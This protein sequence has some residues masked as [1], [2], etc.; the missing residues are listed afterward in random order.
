LAMLFITKV[1]V[2]LSIKC[3]LNGNLFGHLTKL[4]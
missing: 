3:C 2:H 1:I 4:I